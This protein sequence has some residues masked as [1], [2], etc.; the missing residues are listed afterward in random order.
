MAKKSKRQAKRT[1]KVSKPRDLA[2]NNAKAVK[3]GR[4]AGGD[5]QEYLNVKLSDVI[6]S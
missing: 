1:R 4:K 2:A 6:I 3:G 5:Q